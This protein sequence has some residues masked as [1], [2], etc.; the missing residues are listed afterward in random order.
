VIELDGGQHVDRAGADSKRTS[1]LEARG[2]SVLR[3]WNHQVFE[4][5]EGVLE[6]IARAIG[7]P[8]P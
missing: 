4:N 8:S 2:F 1:L 5:L 6:E 3:F 7:Q